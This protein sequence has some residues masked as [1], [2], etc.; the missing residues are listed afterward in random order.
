MTRR[1]AREHLFAL[2]YEAGYDYNG[3]D[4]NDEKLSRNLEEIYSNAMTYQEFEDDSYIRNMFFTIWEYI[5][6]IDLKIADKSVGWKSDRLS[7]VSEAIMRLGVYEI[8]YCEDMPYNIAI[9]E[10]V[11]LAKKYD[12]ENAPKFINGI[13]NA[14]TEAEGLKDKQV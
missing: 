10:A 5:P 8:V 13:L 7:R 14:V 6:E 4:K 12:H 1:E 11:E 2:I 9:N 3:K